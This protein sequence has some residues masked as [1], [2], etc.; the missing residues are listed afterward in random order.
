MAGSTGSKFV[1][2]VLNAVIAAALPLKAG[3][4]QSETV[5]PQ[6]K[7]EGARDERRGNGY[8]PGGELV[9]EGTNGSHAIKLAAGDMVLYPGTSVHKVRPVTRGIR[10]ASFFWVQSMVR[11]DARRAL[12]FDMDGAI[13][14]LRRQHG[15]SGPAIVLTGSYHNLV[16]MWA[17][18]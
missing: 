12:L 9:V 8:Q 16:R 14:T 17:D 11:E 5:L 13:G 18:V 10:T 3:A 15:E 4:Q 7:V 6:V 1:L 2:N